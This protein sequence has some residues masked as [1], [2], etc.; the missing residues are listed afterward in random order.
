MAAGFIIHKHRK[1][2]AENLSH[3]SI[4]KRIL[5][6]FRS[7]GCHIDMCFNLTIE[8][9]NGLRIFTLFADLQATEKVRF[10]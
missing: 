4:A 9:V 10:V 3:L 8:Y 6:M 1:R 2:R 7:Q 5:D